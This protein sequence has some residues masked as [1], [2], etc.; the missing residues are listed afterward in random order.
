MTKKTSGDD[1][2]VLKK[3]LNQAYEKELSRLQIEL[4]KLQEW[5]KHEGLKVVI[6]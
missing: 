4:I 1:S 6:I 3:Q 2:K 5:I